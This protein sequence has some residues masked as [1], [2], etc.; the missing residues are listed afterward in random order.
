MFERDLGYI[1][2]HLKYLRLGEV[3]DYSFLAP[4]GSIK[5]GHQEAFRPVS[6]PPHPAEPGGRSRPYRSSPPSQPQP[7]S[8]SGA[9]HPP[10]RNPPLALPGASPVT[11]TARRGPSSRSDASRLRRPRPQPLPSPPRRR[12]PPALAK[13]QSRPRRRRRRALCASVGAEPGRARAGPGRSRRLSGE[14]SAGRPG[15]PGPRT[16]G[17]MAGGRGAPARP[18]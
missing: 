10:P 11:V 12:P 4:P 16:D 9:G 18:A 8:A 13:L 2:R 7:P 17:G 6:S 5:K 14:P 15:C 1:H 3:G